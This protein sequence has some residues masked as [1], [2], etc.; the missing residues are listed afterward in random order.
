M[1]KKLP[2]A[3]KWKIV[4]LIAV[5]SL[6]ACPRKPSPLPDHPGGKLFHGDIR[7]DVKCHGCHGWLGEGGQSGKPLVQLGRT[8]AHDKFINAVLRGRGGMPA[9]NT[10]LNENDVRQIIDW[11]EKIPQ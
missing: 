9:F 7:L 8:I 11:L 6:S 1:K 2:M 4:L 10:V 5:F 3:K